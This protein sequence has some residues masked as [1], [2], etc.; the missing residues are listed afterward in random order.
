ML[1][2]LVCMRTIL[3]FTSYIQHGVRRWQC[4][5]QLLNC[6]FCSALTVQTNSLSGIIDLNNFT[7]HQ[8]CPRRTKKDRVV[9]RCIASARTPTIYRL[10]LIYLKRVGRNILILEKFDTCFNICKNVIFE[11]V[12]FNHRVQNKRDPSN[13]LLLVCTTFQGTA[14]MVS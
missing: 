7:S 1:H 2:L 14:N 8:G 12:R 10:Q 5:M 6:Q 11:R 3:I 9:L 4:I 13:N